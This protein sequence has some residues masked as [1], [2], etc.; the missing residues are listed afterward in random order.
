M[1][2]AEPN[3]YATL[4]LDCRC[5]LAQIRDAYRLLAKQLHPDLNP[6]SPTALGHTQALNAA[7]ETLGN[8][9]RRRAYDAG[10]DPAWKS[11]A[12]TRPSKTQRNISHEARL[13]L[14]DFLRGTTCAIRVSDPANPAGPELYELVIPPGTAPGTRFRLPRS[15]PFAGGFIQLR[16]GD[17]ELARFLIMRVEARVA[18]AVQDQAE[19]D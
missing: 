12:T 1:Q 16:L 7:Y 9:E 8:P 2:T 14:E 15:G 6:G 13:R 3:H 10:L 18:A 17:A 11:A 4:G 19:Q 5:T